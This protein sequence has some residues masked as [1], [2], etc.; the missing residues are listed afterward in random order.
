MSNNKTNQSPTFRQRLRSALERMTSRSSHPPS[1]PYIPAPGQNTTT[2]V[3]NGNDGYSETEADVQQIQGL[4]ITFGTQTTMQVDSNGHARELSQKPSYILGT[5]KRV[6][7]IEEIGG[8]CP[9]CKL[10]ATQAYEQGLI[11]IQQA[12]LQ[13]LFDVKS[14]LR[15]DIC[16]VNTCSVH[17]RPIQT[18]EDAMLVCVACRE[19]L[20]RRQK[21]AKIISFLLAPFVETQRD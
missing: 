15:C 11:N 2:P 21:R 16:G 18:P 19:E 9:F 8:I 7:S 14:G 13:S 1:Q 10:Q 12:Q 3:F 20:K 5:G 6:S 4:S 17:S